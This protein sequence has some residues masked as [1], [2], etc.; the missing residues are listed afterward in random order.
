MR[1]FYSILFVLF[2]ATVSN[3]IDKFVILSQ[4]IIGFRTIFFC[5]ALRGDSEASPA[6]ANIAAGTL[7]HLQHIRQAA[8]RHTRR[9]GNKAARGLAECGQ[10]INDFVTWMEE[11]PHMIY[12]E[13][14][15][16]VNQL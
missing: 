16:D 13:V 11:T 12:S 8:F 9:V 6:I 7:Q 14:M 15:S 5:S 1:W 10:C 3:F 2:T 4:I